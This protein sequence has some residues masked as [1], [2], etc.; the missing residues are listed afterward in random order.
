[1]LS[2]ML[3]SSL[4]RNLAAG[5]TFSTRSQRRAVSSM[6]VPVLARTCRHELAA[7]GRREKVLAQPRH[8]QP[9]AA[10]RAPQEAPERRRAAA[11]PARSAARW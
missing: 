2:M 8:E 9:G 4:V 11:R 6:R 10:D 5:S 7:V 1:M 3:S